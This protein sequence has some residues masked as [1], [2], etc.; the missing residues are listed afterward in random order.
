MN[1]DPA[2]NA[3]YQAG[4][5]DGLGQRCQHHFAYWDTWWGFVIFCFFAKLATD[6]FEHMMGWS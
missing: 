5:A 6:I 4:R 2:W 1:S 3:G